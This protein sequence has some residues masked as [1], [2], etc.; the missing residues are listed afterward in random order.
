M[1]LD[2]SRPRFSLA[3]LWGVLGFCL[4]LA[5]AIYRLAVLAIE[6]ILD[7]QVTHA[8]QWALYGLSIVFN[9]YAEGYRGFQLK[10]SPRIVARA[11][12]LG[13]NPRP[14][15]VVLAPFFCTALFH[16]TRRRKIVTWT[17]YL[18]L[19]VVITAVRQVPQPWRGIIDA[20]VVVG[21]SWGMASILI[22]YVRALGGNPPQ[23]SPE[24]PGE[25]ER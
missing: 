7:G 20:G 23:V 22:Y 5:Q 12:H 24:L 9:G 18:M 10:A 14:L 25:D 11:M 16:T 19:V 21:L 2:R 4:I 8:W 17:L 13:R 15:H 6:P 1:D 3:A